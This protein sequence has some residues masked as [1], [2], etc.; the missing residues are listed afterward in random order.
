MDESV[1][2]YFSK[3]ADTRRDIIQI[4]ED[5]QNEGI[6]LSEIADKLDMSHVAV[7]KHLDLLLENDY[8]EYL[9]PEGKPKYL[10]LTGEGERALRDFSED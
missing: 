9:N 4:V 1:L 5:K 8:L 7:R 3:G 6:Y 2:F 10:Q